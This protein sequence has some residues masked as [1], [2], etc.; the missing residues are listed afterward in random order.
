VIGERLRAEGLVLGI[1]FL[2]AAAIVAAFGLIAGEVFALSGSDP[3]DE[4]VSLWARSLPL[5]GGVAA[6]RA[7]S[8]LGDW[9]F[10]VP[11]TAT[12]AAVLVLRGR[13]VSSMLFAAAVLGGFGL[14]IVL[15]IAFRRPRPHAA[16]LLEPVTTYSFPSGHAT[17]VTVFFG[18]LAAVVFH[19]TRGP[20]ARNLAVC[21]AALVIVG[22]SFSRIYLGEHWL[23][24][25]SAGI[26]VG[27][28]WVAVS[29]TAT[30]VVA[31]SRR[32]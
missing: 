8:V 25:V 10:L 15:K 19:V 21:L 20:A 7:A 31:G 11:A 5:P 30:E 1:G 18:G 17:M 28:F 14:E 16:T 23:T 22:V 12:V 13:R 27:L 4:E 6:A 26:L 3:L 9:R 2:A 29:A 24:D 32:G